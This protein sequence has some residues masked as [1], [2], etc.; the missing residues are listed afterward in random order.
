M[1]RSACT[2]A[3]SKVPTTC[4]IESSGSQMIFIPSIQ[5]SASFV[6]L[7]IY[8]TSQNCGCVCICFES[9]KL[10]KQ[11]GGKQMHSGLRL[12]LELSNKR[13]TSN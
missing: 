13:P 2:D 11:R 8:V 12:A 4:A 10:L 9:A 7:E 5:A 1:S 3:D 6:I